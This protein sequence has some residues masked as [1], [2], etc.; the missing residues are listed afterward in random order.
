MG[1]G[2]GEGVVRGVAQGEVGFEEGLVALRGEDGDDA[3]AAG[4]GGGEEEGEEVLG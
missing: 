4:V 1:A 3:G 2:V